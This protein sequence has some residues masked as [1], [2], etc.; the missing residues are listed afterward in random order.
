MSNIDTKIPSISSY[1]LSKTQ[2]K[3]DYG[4]DPIMSEKY[5]DCIKITMIYC[6]GLDKISNAIKVHDT[7]KTLKEKDSD[8][9]EYCKNIGLKMQ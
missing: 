6:L 8:F 4:S 1:L 9:F 5:E 7:I 2:H 3:D